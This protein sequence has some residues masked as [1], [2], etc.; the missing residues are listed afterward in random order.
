[1]YT[2]AYHREICGARKSFRNTYEQQNLAAMDLNGLHTNLKRNVENQNFDMK[3]ISL[4]NKVVN[5]SAGHR[6]LCRF[7]LAEAS[8]PINQKSMDSFKML[9]GSTLTSTPEYPKSICS[10]CEA[11]L[12]S[13]SKF[14]VSL[15]DMER[16]WEEFFQNDFRR[17]IKSIHISEEHIY[18]EIFLDIEVDARD[19]Y[20]FVQTFH[21]VVY[22]TM[23]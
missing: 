23:E 11:Q 9:V 12:N 6:Q 22:C 16:C 18:D 4:E 2:K 17:F 7:C 8:K 20:D 14:R 1:M 3:M 5:S 15:L 21:F 19:E 10:L 13:A